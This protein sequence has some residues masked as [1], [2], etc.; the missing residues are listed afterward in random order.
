[1]FGIP[2]AASKIALLLENIFIHQR[3]QADYQEKISRSLDRLVEILEPQALGARSTSFKA[4][5]SDPEGDPESSWIGQTDEVKAAHREMVE[6]FH[7]RPLTESEEREY[8][9][10]TEP[11]PLHIANQK[12]KNA[13][14]VESPFIDGFSRDLAAP[15]EEDP[16]DADNDLHGA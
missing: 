15:L 3:R 1:M 5:Y 16:A 6:R 9:F 12:V 13:K 10:S 7:G 14:R 11:E 8:G 4:G 2:E